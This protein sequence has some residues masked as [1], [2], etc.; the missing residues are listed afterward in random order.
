M[1]RLTIVEH[2]LSQTGQLT[3]VTGRQRRQRNLLVTGVFEHGLGLFEQ[4]FLGLGA[5]RTISVAGLT[6]SAAARTAAE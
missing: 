4:H 6:E 3:V 2:A 5:Q 1:P